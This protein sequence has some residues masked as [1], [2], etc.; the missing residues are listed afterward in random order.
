MMT[1]HSLIF[2]MVQTIQMRFAL[3]R[4]YDGVVGPP[5]GYSDETE[6]CITIKIDYL[7]AM[8]KIYYS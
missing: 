1:D 5:P 7:F 6:V 8:E 2:T 4:A 3:H